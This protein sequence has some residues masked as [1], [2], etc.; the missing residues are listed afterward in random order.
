MLEERSLLSGAPWSVSPAT[1][2]A[3]EGAAIGTAPTGAQV[4]TIVDSSGTLSPSDFS[5]SINWGDG[6]T[7]S[8]DVVLTSQASVFA[9]QGS[10]TYSEEGSNTVR[11]TVNH[12]GSTDTPATITETVAVSDPAVNPSGGMTFTATEG[13][14]GQDQLIATFS[15]PGGSEAAGEYSA[16]INWGDFKSSAATITPSPDG[17]FFL[18]T[19]GSTHIYTEDGNFT[20][21]VVISHD[22]APQATTTSVASVADPSVIAQGGFT[23]TGLEGGVAFNET[24]ATFTDPGG[25]EASSN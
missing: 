19:G 20:I 12:N 23:Y 9:V 2:T 7:T 14:V 5:A 16:T 25:A 8:G 15:D 4:A 21:T 13:A 24:V 10:H 3:Q 22:N 17:T 1:F 18:V 11:V 6:T